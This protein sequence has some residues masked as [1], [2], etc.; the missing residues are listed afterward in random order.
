MKSLEGDFLRLRITEHLA[1]W[2]WVPSAI[3]AL[4]LVL[5][6]A[7]DI[8][9]IDQWDGELPFLKK[10]AAGEAGVADLVAQHLEHRIVF[11]RVVTL[12]VS[13]LAGWR[14]QVS[15][16]V[17]WLLICAV[18]WCL[19]RLQQ[20]VPENSPGKSAYF[21]L[22]A[23]VIL[24]SPQQ[25][26]AWFNPSMMQ[27]FSIE[28]LLSLALVLFATSWP[29]RVCFPL[30]VATAWL[31]TFSSSNGMLLWL[32]LM[33]V[34]AVQASASVR[35]RMVLAWCLA[36]AIAIA[37]YFWGFHKP[38]ESP[39]LVAG[40]GNP[41]AMMGFFLANV[42][43]PL[44]FG[45]LVPPL[46]QA[47]I[48]GV[49]IVAMVVLC[50]LVHVARWRNN[51]FSWSVLPW[52]SLIAYSMATQLAI[53]AGRAGSGPEVALAARYMP[54]ANLTI[55]GLVALVPIVLDELAGVSQVPS[56]RAWLTPRGATTIKAT[57]L[58]VL[59][60]AEALGAMATLP[61]FAN[62]HIRLTA[63]KAAVLFSRC[64]RDP[65]L[66]SNVWSHKTLVDIDA[67]LDF[68]DARGLLRP[69]TFRS[70][71]IADLPR[72]GPQSPTVGGIR[73][74]IEQAGRV[75]EQAV[76]LA[77]WAIDPERRRPADVVLLSWE[78]DAFDATVFAIIPVGIQRP[79]VV[80][81]LS[82]ERFVRAGWGRLFPLEVMPKRPCRIRAWAFDT[83]D[84]T[85]A[86][87]N[88]LVEWKPDR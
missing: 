46:V 6:Y 10:V 67:K 41:L 56:S 38:P 43:A 15:L 81:K 59:L 27:W 47:R 50:G 39:S 72:K 75:N 36:A 21:S 88:G 74:V 66:L 79:D 8:P 18:A 49:T 23:G 24:F 85:I 22:L 7:V 86:E 2:L 52:Y 40:L 60:A 62:E 80:A 5:T 45:A 3:L 87:L 64:F 9:Y 63:A 83:A 55:C 35:G 51:L 65:E 61:T 17:T 32:V 12:A 48:F 57:L 34:M 84:G 20:R 31:A 26:D 53:S 16:V 42:G 29:A 1:A 77:G 4:G 70:C 71:K 14:T 58:S 54:T 78:D 28:F 33:P 37:G 69:K 73:G 30:C 68:M 25:Y 44:A 13:W 76:G 11:S 82:S 19:T